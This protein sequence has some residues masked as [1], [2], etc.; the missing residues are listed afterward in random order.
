MLYANGTK[1][2]NAS[3]TKTRFSTEQRSMGDNQQE[4][5]YQTYVQLVHFCENPQTF[6]G[7]SYLAPPTSIPSS[8]IVRWDHSTPDGEFE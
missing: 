8:P 5:I 1:S 4:R 2:N 7:A 3:Q 6:S